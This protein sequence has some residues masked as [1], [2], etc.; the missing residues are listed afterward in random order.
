MCGVCN[1]LSDDL[2]YLLPYFID[3]SVQFSFLLN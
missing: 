2:K 1:F 3:D